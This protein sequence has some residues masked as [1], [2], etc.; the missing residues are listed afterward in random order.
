LDIND[1]SPNFPKISLQLTLPETSSSSAANDVTGAS[2]RGGDRRILQLPIA[3]DPDSPVNG[4]A[5]FSLQ[6]ETAADNF[7]LI[8]NKTEEQLGLEVVRPVDR[9]KCDHYNL[10]V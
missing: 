2:S 6:P 1:N 8:W 7:R 9:E 4:L 10:Q 5:G 3:V